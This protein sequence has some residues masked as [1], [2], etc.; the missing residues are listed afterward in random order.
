M[1]KDPR[2]ATTPE[3]YA[4]QLTLALQ[5]RDKLSE[6]NAGVI[7]IRE[8]RKQLEDY[9]KRDD[10]RVADA[11]NGADQEADRGRGGAVPDEEP[12]QRGSAELSRSS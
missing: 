1:K 4:K 8:V 9:T 6:T 5:I 11:A 7:R 10:K 3:E 2:L 12:R